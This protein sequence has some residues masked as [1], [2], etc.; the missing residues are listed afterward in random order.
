MLVI[1]FDSNVWR[2]VGGPSRFPND[3]MHLAFTK[4]NEALRL[5]RIEGRLSETIFTLEG[6]ARLDRKSLLGSY[7]PRV[8][9]SAEEVLS[10]GSMRIGL[11]IGPDRSA[12]PGNN[13]Y[14][15]SHLRDALTLGFKLMRCPRVA[16]IVNPDIEEEWY[17]QSSSLSSDMANKFGEVGQRIEAAGAGI[18]W[19]KAIGNRYAGPSEHWTDGLAN[20]PA[21]EQ[22]NIASAVAEWADADTVSAHVAYGNHYICTRDAAKAAGQNSVFSF[23]NRVWLVKEYG[24]KFISPDELATLV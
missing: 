15:S 23:S 24:V 11:N 9:V 14:L 4:I 16:G 7:K 22:K 5:G 10:D 3:S 13:S 12:H 18:A 20:A 21:T 8:N 6:I 19:I 1:T 2:P 17:V